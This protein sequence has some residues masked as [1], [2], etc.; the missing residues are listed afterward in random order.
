MKTQNLEFYPNEIPDKMDWKDAM[1]YCKS[2]G[3]GWRLPKIDKHA[4][5]GC[6]LFF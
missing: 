4:Y 3:E 6:I 5:A 2:L 1:K